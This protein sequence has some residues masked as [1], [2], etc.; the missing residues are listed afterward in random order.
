MVYIL[1]RCSDLAIKEVALFASAGSVS[2]NKKQREEWYL[3]AHPRTR[4]LPALTHIV[5]VP[6]TR[7]QYL[8][9]SILC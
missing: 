9:T 4:S 7:E 5:G 3:S 2:P 6:L 1:T 8:S